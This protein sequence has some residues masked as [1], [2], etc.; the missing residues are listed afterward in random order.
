MTHRQSSRPTSLTDA[1]VPLPL[2]IYHPTKV[3]KAPKVSSTKKHLSDSS[4][5]S[6]LGCFPL[7]PSSSLS[8]K[9]RPSFT[10][11]LQRL[12]G[13]KEGQK[14]SGGKDPPRPGGN[15]QKK[16]QEWFFK[17]TSLSETK[18]NKILPTNPWVTI[19]YYL[20]PILGNSGEMT[21]G[22]LEVEPGDV[23]LEGGDDGDEG[24]ED[25]ANVDARSQSPC[26]VPG[27]G[28]VE[29]GAR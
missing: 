4:L 12:E 22:S 3:L 23:V 20:Q 24:D 15:G 14:L 28:D 8:S 21:D 13:E 9:V 17:A 10:S 5:L 27:W 1:S 6:R 26:I 25:D 16:I 7:L 19:N 11:H 18:V 29:Y 2:V